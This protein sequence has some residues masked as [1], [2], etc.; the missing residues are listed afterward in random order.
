MHRGLILPGV[1]FELSVFC[2]CVSVRRRDRCTCTAL[3]HFCVSCLVLLHA[4][5]PLLSSFRLCLTQVLRTLLFNCFVCA[6]LLLF[7]CRLNSLKKMM[8][9]LC[10]VCCLRCADVFCT[11]C[12]PRLRNVKVLLFTSLSSLLYASAFCSVVCCV[13]ANLKQLFFL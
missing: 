4:P 6:V 8:A 9:L 11:A 13:F 5:P 2:T 10:K 12:A 3:I 7:V 1:C